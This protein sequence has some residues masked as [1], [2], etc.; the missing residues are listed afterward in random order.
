M[1]WKNGALYQHFFEGMSI[2]VCSLAAGTFTFFIERENM[3][4]SEIK[5]FSFLSKASSYAVW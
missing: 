4:P 3:K 2:G 1:S 5:L